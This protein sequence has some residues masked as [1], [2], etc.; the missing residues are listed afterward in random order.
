MQDPPWAFPG[1]LKHSAVK[2]SAYLDPNSSSDEKSDDSDYGS[3]SGE[4]SLK[5]RK[6]QKKFIKLKWPFRTD[7]F[8]EK[9][10]IAKKEA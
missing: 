9:K 3:D 10:K 7:E 6:I 1:R 4:R 2:M 5:R 8:R